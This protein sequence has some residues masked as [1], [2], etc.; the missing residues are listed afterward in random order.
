MSTEADVP[1][2]HADIA[3]VRSDIGMVFLRLAGDAVNV[4]MEMT[5]EEALATARLLRDKAR[6]ALNAEQEANRR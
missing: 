2:L 6:E 1:L 4:L 3:F 5:P